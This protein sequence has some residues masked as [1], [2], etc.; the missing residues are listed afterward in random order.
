MLSSCS[1]KPIKHMRQMSQASYQGC[2]APRSQEQTPKRE[3]SEAGTQSPP[4]HRHSVSLGG[5][6]PCAVLLQCLAHY[7]CLHIA[8]YHWPGCWA[9][10]DLRRCRACPVPCSCL[11][12][13][14]QGRAAAACSLRVLGARAASRRRQPGARRQHDHLQRAQWPL[15]RRAR[16]R[17]HPV[18]CCGFV[19]TCGPVQALRG[20]DPVHVLLAGYCDGARLCG[21]SITLCRHV[22]QCSRRACGTGMA[23]KVA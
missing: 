11:S 2:A 6:L 13:R 5:T 22:R 14:E 16:R 21:N 18:R 23:P 17:L 1:P 12:S 4:C 10:S 3:G 19:P 8:G 9:A 7:S 20:Y 15:I